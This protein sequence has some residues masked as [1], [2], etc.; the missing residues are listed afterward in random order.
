MSKGK[1]VRKEVRKPKKIAQQQI[2]YRPAGL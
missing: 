2:L 1:N